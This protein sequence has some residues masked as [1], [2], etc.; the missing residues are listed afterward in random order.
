MGEDERERERERERWKGRVLMEL[1]NGGHCG[2]QG[3]VPAE[4]EEGNF[5]TERLWFGIK[6][7]DV[8]SASLARTAKM[9]QTAWR[10]EPD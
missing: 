2:R 5:R 7:P 9:N 6:W 4:K 8:S 10:N 3:E 1:K